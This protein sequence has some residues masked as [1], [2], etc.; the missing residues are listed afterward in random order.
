MGGSGIL[1][2]R[3]AEQL[4]DQ[5]HKIHFIGYDTDQHLDSL[6]KKGVKLHKVRK[7]DYPCLKNEPYV[8]TLANKICD[9]F[10]KEKLDLIHVHYAIPHALAAYIAKKQLKQEGYDLPYI[11][12][13][14]GSDIHTNGNKE[15]INSIL[16]LALNKADYITYVSKNLK[17]YAE[18]KL[19]IIKNG[20]YITNFIDTEKFSPG[21]S[22][23][24]EK[25]NISKNAFIIGHASNFAQIKQ[26]HYFIELAKFLK[27]KRKIRLIYFLLCGDGEEK[28]KIQ[29]LAK[30]EGVENHFIFTGKLNEKLMKSAYNSMD[31][32]ALTS[33]KEGCPLTILEALSSAVP[34]ISTN[35]PGAKE[36][37]KLWGKREENL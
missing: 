8:W 21:K 11:V 28:E 4:A 35:F 30:E 22:N 14:H 2:I 7:I 15:D 3:L 18:E 20:K 29:K 25:Y 17:K 31:V 23:L 10:H 5:G 19:G 33:Y 12:T 6:E 1:T 16:R 37:I 32:F 24:R 36:L 27:K 9:V 13:G 34:V 26:T